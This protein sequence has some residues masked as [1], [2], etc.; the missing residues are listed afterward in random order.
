MSAV[1]IRRK[2]AVKFCSMLCETSEVKVKN[3]RKARK[4]ELGRQIW[5]GASV[6]AITCVCVCGGGEGK[7]RRG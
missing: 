2:K 7:R 4:E 3:R 1:K 5:V 6:Y